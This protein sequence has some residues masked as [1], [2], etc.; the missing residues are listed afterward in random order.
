[1]KMNITND[2]PNLILTE[3]L[4]MQVVYLVLKYL[5]KPI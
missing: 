5:N 3:C 2:S 4:T 1:M